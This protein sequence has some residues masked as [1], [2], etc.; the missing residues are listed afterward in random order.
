M[1]FHEFGSLR[2][3]PPLW[4]DLMES[5]P[6]CSMTQSLVSIV[7]DF[8]RLLPRDQK[9]RMCPEPG[10]WLLKLVVG[11]CHGMEPDAAANFFGPELDW[12]LVHFVGGDITLSE[13]AEIWYLLCHCHIPDIC[14]LAGKLMDMLSIWF[15]LS[16]EIVF[17]GLVGH[18]DLDT[19]RVSCD[20]GNLGLP[21]SIVWRF[22]PT[23]LYF[24]TSKR[25]HYLASCQ[26][27][28]WWGARDF[29]ACYWVIGYWDELKLIWKTL[30][31]KMKTI[32]NHI[33]SMNKRLHPNI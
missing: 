9:R 28:R 16:S 19:G 33:T 14:V 24:Y 31:L 32:N 15:L 10:L 12:W 18:A 26:W 17:T 5:V 4:K 21:F 8:T 3:I 13:S 23:Q 20:K 30:L 29:M 1:K 22:L 7:L 2:P 6:L 11:A 27:G 25:E